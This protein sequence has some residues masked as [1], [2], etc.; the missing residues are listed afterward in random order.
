MAVG[1]KRSSAIPGDEWPLS[2]REGGVA[3]EELSGL[4]ISCEALVAEHS[5]EE[6]RTEVDDLT[7]LASSS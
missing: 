7:S 3:R 5:R 4:G 6:I 1:Q 2:S